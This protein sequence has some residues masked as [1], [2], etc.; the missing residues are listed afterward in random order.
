MDDSR[1][2]HWSDVDDEGE[3]KKKIHDLRWEVYVKE[4]EYL[5]KMEVFFPVPHPKWGGIVWTYA[6]DHA[7]QNRKV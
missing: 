7:G 3:D 5:I 4:N 1:E 2:E 6:K